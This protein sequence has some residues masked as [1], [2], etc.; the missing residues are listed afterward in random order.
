MDGWILSFVLF[1]VLPDGSVAEQRGRVTVPFAS[2]EVCAA[3][4]ADF[5]PAQ[6]PPPPA[7]NARLAAFSASCSPPEPPARDP[8]PR[9]RTRDDA[10]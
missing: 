2:F 7:Q 8:A 1:F 5:H 10:A 6:L 9:T 4:L 3:A